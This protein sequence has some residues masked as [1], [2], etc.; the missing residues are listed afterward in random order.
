[1]LT[2]MLASYSRTTQ[3]KIRSGSA[4]ALVLFSFSREIK[5][6]TNVPAARKTQIV[7][8]SNMAAGFACTIPRLG[9]GR[10]VSGASFAAKSHTAT[11]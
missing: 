1:M 8:L 3:R 7:T 4:V 9:D 11:C 10:C 2:Q 6:I 5:Y